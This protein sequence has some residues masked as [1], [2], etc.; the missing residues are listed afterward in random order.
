[1]PPLGAL[2]PPPPP[3]P[4]PLLPP[5]D[6]PPLELPPELGLELE[7]LLELLLDPGLGL[8]LSD[9]LL[10]DEL[11]VSGDP[12]QPLLPVSL[13]SLPEPLRQ[14]LVDVVPDPPR[15]DPDP[16]VGPSPP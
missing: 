1:M 13:E 3:L 10:L 9:K 2:L 8:L 15:P 12:R 5:P 14:A 16:P 7:L 6:E 4:P 11:L